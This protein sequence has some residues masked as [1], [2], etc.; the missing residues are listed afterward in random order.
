MPLNVEELIE[1]SKEQRGRKRYE[2]ALVSALAAA[3]QDDE[4]SEAWWQVALSRQAVS[5]RV[6]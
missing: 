4:N 6:V 5:R 3:E 1:K 2:E